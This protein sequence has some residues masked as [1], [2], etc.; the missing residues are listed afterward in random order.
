MKKDC[1]MKNG[2]SYNLTHNS[3]MCSIPKDLQWSISVS[4][5]IVPPIHWKWICAFN[6]SKLLSSLNHSPKGKELCWFTFVVSRQVVRS[7][8]ATKRPLHASLVLKSICRKPSSSINMYVWKR[9]VAVHIQWE[10][11]WWW[12]HMTV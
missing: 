6:V 9:E 5:T 4:V 8:P 12:T 11:S 3:S 2:R 10:W 1:Q 7:F